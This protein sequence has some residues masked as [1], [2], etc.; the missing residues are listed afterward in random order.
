MEIIDTNNYFIKTSNN[1]IEIQKDIK[2]NI[3]K[4]FVNALFKL[5]LDDGKISVEEYKKLIT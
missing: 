1:K 4:E 5:L 2:E 3:K